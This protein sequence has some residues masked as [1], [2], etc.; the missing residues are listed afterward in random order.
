MSATVIEWAALCK[1]GFN[2]PEEEFIWS[3]HEFGVSCAPSVT[4]RILFRTY[5]RRGHRLHYWLDQ[6]ASAFKFELL[7]GLQQIEITNASEDESICYLRLEPRVHNPSDVRDLGVLVHRIWT[8][9]EPPTGGTIL[10]AAPS[11]F[12]RTYI[13]PGFADAQSQTNTSSFFIDAS[14]A[15]VQQLLPNGQNQRFEGV[16]F[17]STGNILGVATSDA[18]S[19]QL[20]RRRDGRRFE[21]QPYT[22]ISGLK[23]PHDLAFGRSNNRAL[24]AIAERRGAIAVYQEG[25][26]GAFGDVPSCVLSGAEARLNY[27]DGVAFVPPYDDHVAACN[28]ERG[29]I[30]F[31]GQALERAGKFRATP[32]LELAHESMGGPDGLAFSGD[33]RWLAVANHEAHSISLFER[34]GPSYGPEPTTVIQDPDLRH[35]HS[36]AFT[37]GGHLIATSAGTNFFS[38]YR[39]ENSVPERICRQTVNDE[40]V[41][42][43]VNTANKQEGGPKGVAIHDNTIAVCSPE[44]GIKLY[45]FR[46][47]R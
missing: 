33:G 45:P 18:N 14:P 40:S 4:T 7:D 6:N 11:S 44:I 23:Y 43:Q 22:T 1:Y 41:F 42:H 26:D 30:T 37:K 10:P 12:V 35:P 46:E 2:A 8:G 39:L 19:V 25:P 20:F 13:I 29:A 32:V 3:M 31:Y 38:V 9:G 15:S 47:S 5:G 21:E 16:A 27:T 36:V 34:R 24:L 17:S 28:L